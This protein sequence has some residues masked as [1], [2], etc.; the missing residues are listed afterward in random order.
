[1]SKHHATLLWGFRGT[2]TNFYLLCQRQKED[3][4]LLYWFKKSGTQQR[5]PDAGGFSIPLF[6]PPFYGVA[7]SMDKRN[8]KKRHLYKLA[9]FLDNS[10][11]LPGTQYKV[12]ADAII[13][14]IPGIG[15]GIGTLLS[16]YILVAAARMGVPKKIL[17]RMGYNIAVETVIGL[18]PFIGDAFDVVWKANVRNVQLLEDYLDNPRKTKTT[19]RFFIVALVAAFTL[20]F[21]LIA[22]AGFLILRWLWLTIAA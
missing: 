16:S 8:I 7:R 2:N 17:L 18:I 12:G 21:I 13:G 6:T 9:W 19:S 20:I 11:A 22:S 1:M 5:T 15:D 4:A 3:G 10:V 14:L